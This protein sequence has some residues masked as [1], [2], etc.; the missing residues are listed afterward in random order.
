MLLLP[1]PAT[2]STLYLV[3]QPAHQN[4]PAGHCAPRQHADEQP[5]RHMLCCA[6]QGWPAYSAV[7]VLQH[8]HAKLR[9][10]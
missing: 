10:M 5:E 6:L 9:S 1:G 7:N 4:L 2:L 8:F 3:N